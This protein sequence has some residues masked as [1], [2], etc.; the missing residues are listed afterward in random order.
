MSTILFVFI[1]TIIF[2]SVIAPLWLLLHYRSRN[3][4]GK[5]LNATEKR[6]LEAL[7]AQA[8]KLADRV[9]TLERILD[10]ENPDWRREHD[11]HADRSRRAL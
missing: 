4:A 11:D 7:L 6:E 8:D 10:V 3:R 5:A 1:P 9:E 2:M